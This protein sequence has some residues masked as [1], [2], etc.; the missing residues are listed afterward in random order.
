MEDADDLMGLYSG[1]TRTEML[2][3]QAAGSLPAKVYLYQW[4]I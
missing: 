1:P 4:N 2:G 3:G